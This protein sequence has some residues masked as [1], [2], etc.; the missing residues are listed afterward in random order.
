M[1]Y[2]QIDRMT[3]QIRQL[4]SERDTARGHAVNLQDKI[5]SLQAELSSQ[6]RKNASKR[7]G[8]KGGRPKKKTNQ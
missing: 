2:Q 3:E 5:E 8:L 6:A 1:T 4:K 7:N